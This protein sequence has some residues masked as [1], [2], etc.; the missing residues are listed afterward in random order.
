MLTAAKTTCSTSAEQPADMT[1]DILQSD[2][3]FA[4]GLI[5]GNRQD[6]EVVTALVRRGIEVSAATRLVEDLRHSRPVRPQAE[7]PYLV[8]AQ[9][10]VA[11]RTA[12]KAEQR[13]ASPS[14][15]PKSHRHSSRRSSQK[16][17]RPVGT[18]LQIHNAIR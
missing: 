16:E 3:D 17:S 8:S 11:R 7:S 18:A 12:A 10:A 9:A 15:T 6:N 2:I 5:S 13:P 1:H 4:K 14:E